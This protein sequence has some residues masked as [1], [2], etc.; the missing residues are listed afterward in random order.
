MNKKL[1]ILIFSPHALENGR[2]GE[3]S[4]MELAAG[5]QKYFNVTFFDTNRLFGKKLLTRREINSKLKGVK[6]IRRLKFATLNILNRNFS[7]PY[8]WE[9]LKLYRIIKNQDIFYTSYSNFKTNVMVIFFKLLLR[10]VKFIIG[11]RKPLHSE[12]LIS[13]YNLK[14]RTSILFLS[15]FKK[16]I[17]HHTLSYQAKKF[18]ENFYNP[19]SI[20]HITHGIELEKYKNNGKE[21]KRSDI[22]NFIYVGYLDDVHK[23]VGVLIKGIEQFLE[24]YRDLKIFFEFCGMGPLERKI[25]ELEQRYPKFVKFHG[26]ISNEDIPKYYKSADVY[27]FTSRQEPF[28]RVLMEALAANHIIICT[29]TIGSYELLNGKEFAFFIQKLNPELISEKILEVYELWINNQQKFKNLQKLS[30]EFVFQN[31]STSIEIKMFKDLIQNI[32]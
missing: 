22:L 3:I 31:Y 16:R 20:I 12:K 4:S 2:G 32:I 14:Y 30:K 23:G 1:N 26:Y 7:F 13:L 25:K 11:Y 6:K 5:F 9:I 19:K 17:Y 18:L 21:K 15:L 8:P 29:K 28:P 24:K 10:S 27:L